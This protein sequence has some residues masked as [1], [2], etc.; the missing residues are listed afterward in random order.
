MTCIG[1][2]KDCQYAPSVM[3]CTKVN[4]DEDLDVSW[5]CESDIHQDYSLK[6]ISVYCGVDDH[7]V[8][9]D[10]CSV[11]YVVSRI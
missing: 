8:D 7:T 1:Y 3:T 11:E 5:K 2:K 6:Y 9:P 4:N 10:K